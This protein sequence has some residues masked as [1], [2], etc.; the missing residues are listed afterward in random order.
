[1]W[2][3]E[4]NL[5]SAWGK[6]MTWF[7]CGSRKGLGFRFRIQLDLFFVS[8]HRNYLGF[9]VGMEI[10]LV[11]VLGSSELDRNCLGFSVGIAIPV[12]FV[13]EPKMTCF[14]CGYRL[15]WLLCGW[16][17]LTWFL[18]RGI[19]IDLVVCSTPLLHEGFNS[20]LNPRQNL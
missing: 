7:L 1:M 10:D 11:L 17:K 4:I 13:C 19:V 6:E 5:I 2:G 14:Q 3:I 16:S 9:R 8:G 12:V 18:C 15:P 20:T